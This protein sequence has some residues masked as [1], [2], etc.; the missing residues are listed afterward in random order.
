M[1]SNTELEEKLRRI[2]VRASVYITLDHLNEEFRKN[3]GKLNG[4]LI[5][6]DQQDDINYVASEILPQSGCFDLPFGEGNF[7]I[8]MDEMEV[9][10][11]N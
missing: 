7:F 8:E 2:C 1:S 10:E 9:E 5:S 3:I 6:E 11:I 4:G